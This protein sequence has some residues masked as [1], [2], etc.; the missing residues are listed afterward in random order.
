MRRYIFLL[1][2]LFA[3]VPFIADACPLCQGGGGYSQATLASYKIITGFLASLPMI[4]GGGIFW[5]IHK[6]KKNLEK[7]YYSD[8][9]QKP[10]S[11]RQIN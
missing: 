5:W 10:K 11:D 3:T 9:L 8:A 4:M 1:V 7:T 6:K 2:V